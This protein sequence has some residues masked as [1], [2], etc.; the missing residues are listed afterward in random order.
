GRVHLQCDECSRWQH[1]TCNSGVTQQH[2]RQ[3]QRLESFDWLCSLCSWPVPEQP[4][5]EQ[6]EPEQPDPERIDWQEQK[7]QGAV[8]V[9]V[10]PPQH[11]A[12]RIAVPF[13]IVRGG[14]TRGKDSLVVDSRFTFVISRRRGEVVYW[15]CTTRNAKATCKATVTQRG[16]L[17]T[18]G[19][20][21]HN[22]EEQYRPAERKRLRQAVAARARA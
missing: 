7:R 22:H 21:Q 3:L 6:P 15:R 2:Y 19:P 4:D 17:F 10:P 16:N 18:P 1:R 12:P 13:E 11:L 5:P 8:P 20:A 9:E 14:S